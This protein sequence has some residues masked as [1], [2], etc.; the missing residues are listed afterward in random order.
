M[1]VGFIVL[2]TVGANHGRLLFPLCAFGCTEKRCVKTL[3][4]KWVQLIRVKAG[5]RQTAHTHTELDVFANS[6]KSQWEQVLYNPASPEHGGW[7][8]WENCRICCGKE[9]IRMSKNDALCHHSA[10]HPWNILSKDNEF[11]LTQFYASYDPVYK[12]KTK[13]TFLASWISGLFGA[14]TTIPS[15]C[16]Q[17]EK[18]QKTLPRW[19]SAKTFSP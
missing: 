16:V 19:R 9:A 17:W 5:C 4:N 18:P 10:I 2:L 7:C 3:S 1:N 12:N 13:T 11:T 6:N 15:C 14:S 8:G